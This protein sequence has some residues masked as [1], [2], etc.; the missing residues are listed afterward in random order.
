M[1]KKTLVLFLIFLLICSCLSCSDGNVYG[2]AELV[3]SLS[4]DFEEFE[5]ENFDAAYTNGK[6]IVGIYRISFE[7]G[8]NQGIPDFLTPEQFARFY[9]KN[10]GKSVEIKKHQATPYYEYVDEQDGIKNTYIATFYR[11][12]FAY[13]LVLFATPES[14]YTQTFE[15]LISYTETVIFDY[16]R[17]G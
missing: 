2:H 7:A 4:E 15:E 9:M 17:A 8:F 16:D 13:F 6:A 10:S 5:A 3:I 14:L 11:S 12:R 1:L